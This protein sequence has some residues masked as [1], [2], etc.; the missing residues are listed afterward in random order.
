M[1]FSYWYSLTEAFTAPDTQIIGA[2]ARGF[3]VVKTLLN[4]Y[5]GKWHN[6]DAAANAGRVYRVDLD[7]GREIHFVM[8]GESVGGIEVP[9]IMVMFDWSDPD[10]VDDEDVSDKE[11]SKYLVQKNLSRHTM[12][13]M[14]IMRNFFKELVG[15]SVIVIY[16]PVGPRRDSLYQGMLQSLGYTKIATDEGIQQWF[17]AKAMVKM[18][19]AS[20][21]ARSRA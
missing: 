16:H 20:A 19:S 17:P 6:S 12:Q 13:F 9:S 8:E 7:D 10:F 21:L 3:S 1:N 15:Y 4:K 5:F 2:D 18:R 11:K 14:H